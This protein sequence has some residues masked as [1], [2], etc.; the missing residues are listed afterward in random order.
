[1]VPKTIRTKVGK[2]LDICGSRSFA[3]HHF[4]SSKE[5]TKSA[6]YTC[7]TR[8]DRVMCSNLQSILNI[9]TLQETHLAIGRCLAVGRRV[10]RLTGR[11]EEPHMVETSYGGARLCRFC[12]VF[13]RIALMLVLGKSV[14]SAVFQSYLRFF[15]KSYLRLFAGFRPRKLQQ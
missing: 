2:V 7:D 11:E 12:P 3:C 14:L 1:V 10:V 15:L 8:A 4:F 6:S 13:T 5:N 9:V